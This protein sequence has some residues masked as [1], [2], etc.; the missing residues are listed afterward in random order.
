MARKFSAAQLTKSLLFKTLTY[1]AAGFLGK[2]L[3]LL[4]V[5]RKAL[6]KAEKDASLEGVATGAFESLKRLVRLVKAYAD[7]SYRGVSRKNVVLVV[8]TILYF[9]SPLDIVP[10]AI[11]FIGLLDDITLMGWM[12]KTLG[13]ELDRFEEFEA[14][15]PVVDDI[16]GMNY[17]DL[18]KRAQANDIKGR[19][20]MNRAELLDALTKRSAS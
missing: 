13:E 19:S 12:I 15:T 10:D 1:R 16:A 17:Q 8:A 7:G 11:P 14:R 9:V 20:G 18:Y 2:P 5:A 6:A 4:G 3:L